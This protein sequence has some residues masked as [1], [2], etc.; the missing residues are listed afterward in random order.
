MHDFF[1]Q[2]RHCHITDHVAY[3]AIAAFALSAVLRGGFNCPL[4]CLYTFSSAFLNV[5]L[6]SESCQIG[7]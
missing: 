1:G 2:A 7:C 5:S 4:T 6:G 3:V